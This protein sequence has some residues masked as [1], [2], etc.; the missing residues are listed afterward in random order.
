MRDG[1][2]RIVRCRIESRNEP[3]A[4]MQHRRRHKT[5]PHKVSAR[6]NMHVAYRGLR[7]FRTARH[8]LARFRLSWSGK[9]QHAPIHYIMC[10]KC[11]AQKHSHSHSQNRTVLAWSEQTTRIQLSQQKW[12]KCIT[13]ALKQQPF[14]QMKHVSLCTGLI[15]LSLSQWRCFVARKLVHVTQL[16]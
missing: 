15:D 1:R 10:N 16:L 12:I 13:F 8:N 2:L 9:K 7:S 5:A 3:S 14:G 11:V 6:S 4:K